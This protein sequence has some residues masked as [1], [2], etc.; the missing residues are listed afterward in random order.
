LH[1]REKRLLDSP[2]LSVRPRVYMKNLDS[3]AT[4][5]VKFDTNNFIKIYLKIQIYFKIM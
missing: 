4:I 3:T 5:F 2:C 1:N